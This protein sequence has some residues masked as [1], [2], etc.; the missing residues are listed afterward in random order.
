MSQAGTL[1]QLSKY[2]IKGFI[3]GAI[4]PFCKHPNLIFRRWR[5]DYFCGMCRE[6]FALVDGKVMHLG[7]QDQID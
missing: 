1:L 6:V 3:D 4:C 2:Q 5:D 7:H